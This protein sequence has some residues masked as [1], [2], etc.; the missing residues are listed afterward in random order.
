MKNRP[1]AIK[2]HM[3]D[4]GTVRVASL[5]S[6]PNAV[7]LSKPTRLNTA[8]TTPRPR[9]DNETPV[10]V[11]WLESI[12]SPCFPRTVRHKTMINRHDMHSKK[13]MT[14]VDTLMSLYASR[15]QAPRHI[16]NKRTGGRVMP[17]AARSFPAKMVKP[18]VPARPMKRYAQTR[19]HP[20]MHPALGPKPNDVYEYIEPV[21]T[22]RL[23]N[24]FRLKATNRS[25]IVPTAYESQLMFPVLENISGTINAAVMVGDIRAMFC[26][27]NSTKFRQ[28]GLSWNSLLMVCPFSLMLVCGLFGSASSILPRPDAVLI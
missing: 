9:L 1:V 10:N 11:N 8:T 24:W 20:D 5:V 27:S 7:E 6:S 12:A 28:F 2:L 3:M 4:S 17:I 15:K 13:S 25:M 22:E 21:P 19:H 23:A 14:I 16:A 26:A 18:V